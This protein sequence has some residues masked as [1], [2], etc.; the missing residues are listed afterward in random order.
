MRLTNE[1]R[2][3]FSDKVMANI[4]MKS[5]WTEEKIRA[6]VEKRLMATWP[7]D[8]I[9]FKKKYPEQMNIVSHCI[10]YMPPHLTIKDRWIYATK[11]YG[12]GDKDIEQG[13][14]IA[15]FKELVAEREARKEMRSR[16]YEQTCGC[17]TT[18]QLEV[19]FPDL[20][21]FIP[22]DVVTVK[23]LPVAAKGLVNDLVAI[24]LVVPI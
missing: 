17:T 23:S 18:N 20:K 12:V 11:I 1:M 24:G 3:K 14:L 21:G 22:K 4:P 5:D 6:E 19:V 15:A 7:K 2:N 16:I 13:D 10:N 9:E 8:V